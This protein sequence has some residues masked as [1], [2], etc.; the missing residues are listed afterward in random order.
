MTRAV[1]ALGLW[2]AW[3]P[4]ACALVA[5][6]AA[7]SPS[8]GADAS[9][10]SIP[11]RDRYAQARLDLL[12]A[13]NAD[14]AAAGV[15][16]VALDSLATVV[17]QAHAEAMA[18]YGFFSHYGP[19]G[20]APYERL[21]EAGGTVHVLENV[22]RWRQ[23][24]SSPPSV[25]DPW[26]RFD[27]L[28]AEA[29][30]MSSPAH[31]RT[32]LSP[33]RTAVGLGLAVDRAKGAVYVVQDFIARYLDLEV[34]RR[35]WRASS[36]QVSGRARASGVR[37]LLI[38]LRREVQPRAWQARE[39]SPPGGPYADGTGEGTILPPWAIEW[40][41]T[42]R[43]FTVTLPIGRGSDPGRY[44]GI[45]YVAPERIVRRALDRGSV[46]TEDGW[47]GGAFVIELL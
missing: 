2:L 11:I 17:A 32:I 22:F 28:R 37:P 3:A 9:P 27:V 13:I 24:A 42:D 36:T 5:C 12:D 41:P 44:Y 46:D 33:H 21:A 4:I 40:R 29:R 30:L 16:P 10:G 20:D 34:P 47:P 31:R 14:R 35:A 23:R 43:S 26:A 1:V 7:V 45:V 15:A 38:V 39:E 18:A 8:V 25:G 6:A 19:A